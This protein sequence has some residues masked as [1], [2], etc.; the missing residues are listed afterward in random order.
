MS[1]LDL[2]EQLL[3]SRAQ[4]GNAAL[5]QTV[6]SM[7]N[8]HPGGLPGLVQSFEQ[9]GLGG[10]VQSWVGN[11]Q[12]QPVSGEQVQ[13]VLGND[14]VQEVASKLGISASEASSAIAQVLPHVVDHLTPNGQVPAS[15][16]NL[17]EMGEGLLRSFLK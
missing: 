5:L 16:S 13:N 15:G 12:N 2:A 10:V 6:L 3:G 4:G 17:M 9:Q 8:N 7:V 14:K 11:G 1:L